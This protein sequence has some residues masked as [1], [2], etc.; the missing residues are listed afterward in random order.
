MRYVLASGAVVLFWLAL[1]PTGDAGGKK[2]EKPAP[3]QPPRADEMPKYMKM[4]MATSGKDR[5]TAAH[6]IGLRGMVNANDVLD[7]IDPLRTALE[8]DMDANVRKEAARALGNI[9]PD[10]KDTVPLLTRTVKDDKVMDVR[11]AA[12]IALGQYGAEAKESLPTLRDFAG[13]LKDKKSQQAQTIAQAI[14]SI[15]GKKK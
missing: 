1:A 14:K 12:T 4:L 9:Q 2:K 7:A 5:A 8:K 13:E 11:L 3:D 6:M 10:P 15:S